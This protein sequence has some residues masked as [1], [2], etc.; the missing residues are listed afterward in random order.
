MRRIYR[1]DD[2]VKETKLRII[3]LT[4]GNIE[5][6][7]AKYGI[8]DNEVDVTEKVK[9]LFDDKKKTIIAGN[10]L[11]GDPAPGIVKRLVLEYAINGIKYRRIIKEGDN[12]RTNI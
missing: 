1:Y 11:G 10:Y 4:N 7:I 6:L 12:I 2:Y 5:I 3:R 8:D 9:K